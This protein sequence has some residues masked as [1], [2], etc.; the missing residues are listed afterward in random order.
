MRE[1]LESNTKPSVQG[2]KEV[3]APTIGNKNIKDSYQ[4]S[5]IMGLRTGK[6]FTGTSAKE[7]TFLPEP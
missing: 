7:G 3:T 1:E 4:E 6:N 5:L 2:T